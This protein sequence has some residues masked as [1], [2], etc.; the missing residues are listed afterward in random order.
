MNANKIKETMIQG[1][2]VIFIGTDEGENQ[3]TLI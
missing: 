1:F 2:A 3:L